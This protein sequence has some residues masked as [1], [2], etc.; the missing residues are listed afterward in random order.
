MGSSQKDLFPFDYHRMIVGYHG[1]DRSVVQKVLLQGEPLH[2]SDNLFDW[3]GK[4]IYFWEYAPQ[5]ALDFAREQKERG[6]VKE[7]AVLGA[8][9]H[10]GRCFDLTDTRNTKKLIE[11]FQEF[12]VSYAQTGQELPLN[13]KGKGSQDLL[14]RNLDCAVL[15]WYM[16][17]LDLTFSE[18]IFY[19]TIRGVFVEGEPIYKGAG[20]YEKTHTQIA[21]RDPLCILGYF[22][23]AIRGES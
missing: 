21:V 19:Q 17:L 11:A 4:G 10:L 6:K 22:L 1:C 5:R 15:N 8:Y 7:P 16:S 9:L 14:L 20:I 3:L 23:P 13:K 2:P 12:S 18:G